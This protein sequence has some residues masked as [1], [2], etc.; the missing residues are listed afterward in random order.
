M[1]I[2]KIEIESSVKSEYNRAV[3]KFGESNNSSHESY[4]I[5]REEL[6][7][8]SVDFSS[9]NKYLNDFWEAVKNNKE[10]N[11]LILQV[12]ALN[13]LKNHAINAACELVQVA[14]MAEKALV[15]ISQKYLSADE[16]AAIAISRFG[17]ACAEFYGNEE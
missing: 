7:E 8:A 11:S 5:I 9:V 15:T 4:A 12:E 13:S 14:A 6:E 16:R 10:S 3:E 2:L 1:K 17:R